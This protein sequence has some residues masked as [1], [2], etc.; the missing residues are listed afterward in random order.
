MCVISLDWLEGRNVWKIGKSLRKK[1]MGYQIKENT[2]ESV[3]YILFIMLPPPP[4]LL[5]FTPK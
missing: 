4:V 3:D 1:G 5:C 2:S